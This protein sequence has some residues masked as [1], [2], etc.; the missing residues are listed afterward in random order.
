MQPEA[1]TA[2]PITLL[3]GLLDEPLLLTVDK[4]GKECILSNVCTHRGNLLVEAPGPRQQLV[5]RYHGRCFNLDGDCLRQPG[6][7]KVIGFPGVEDHLARPV[8][9]QWAGLRFV[10][11][12]E[13]LDFESWLQPVSERTSFLPWHTLRYREES[14][15]DYRVAAHWALYCDNYLEG[16]HIPFVHPGL[17]EA[18][19]LDA[20]PVHTFPYGSLQIGLAKSGEPAFELPEG[21]PDT[22]LRVYAWYFWLFPN[23]MINVYP[24]GL[25]INVVEPQG[26]NLTRVRYLT[27]TFDGA[28]GDSEGHALHATEMEDEAIVEKVQIGTR[29]HLYRP[30]KMV[31]EWEKAVVH[32]HELLLKAMG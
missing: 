25:S 1:G 15:R 12:E 21:H 24:W 10:Q 18:L 9:G 20:Y 7:G 14:S 5:C 4:S 23:I 29:A 16:L 2:H 3:P 26:G 19:D 22:G 17:R 13:G 6:L 30:G 31:P 11:M 8:T 27:Y 28:T 32:F